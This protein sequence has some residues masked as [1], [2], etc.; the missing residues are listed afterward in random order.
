MAHG[1]WGW[2]GHPQMAKWGLFKNKKVK[3]NKKIWVLLE[4]PPMAGLGV[5]KT[6]PDHWGVVDQAGHRGRPKPP[7][8]HLGWLSHLGVVLATPI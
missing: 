7:P 5:A 1:H 2:F 8:S 4:P 6:T 3:K